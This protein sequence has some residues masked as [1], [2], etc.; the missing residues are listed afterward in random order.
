MPMT[1]FNWEESKTQIF[2]TQAKP[3]A[4]KDGRIFPGFKPTNRNQQNHEKI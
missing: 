1:L 3:Q 4:E 2:Q